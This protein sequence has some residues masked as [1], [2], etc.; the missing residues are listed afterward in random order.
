MKIER[1]SNVVDVMEYSTLNYYIVLGTNLDSR[2]NQIPKHVDALVAT[3]LLEDA[4]PVATPYTRDTGKGQANTLCELSMTEKAIHMSGSGLLQYVALYRVDVVFA[5]KAVRSRT[6][7]GDVLA[8]LS[9][10]RVARH[11]V[12][13]CEVALNYPYQRHTITGRL[14]HGRRLGWRCGNT[15]VNDIWSVFF[16]E[17]TGLKD[18]Q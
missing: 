1:T 17:L 13:H 11:L 15:I 2:I 4:R 5:T 6:A 7:K 14:L 9:L 16:M 10:K 8:L 12:C 3:L 18:G